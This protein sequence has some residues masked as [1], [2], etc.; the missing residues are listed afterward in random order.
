MIKENGIILS[1]P[2]ITITKSFFKKILNQNIWTQLMQ[3]YITLFS[4]KTYLKSI[5][6]ILA[7]SI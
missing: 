2:L 1:N 3:Y 5:S 6:L 7:K 4:I